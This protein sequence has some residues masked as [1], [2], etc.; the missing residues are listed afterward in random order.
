M[1]TAELKA[2]I[3][4]SLKIDPAKLEEAL[5]AEAETAVE[6][7]KDL[8]VLDEAGL[9]QLKNNEYASGKTKGVEMA[10]K[11]AKEKLGVETSSK[12]VDGLVNAATAKAL[13]DAKITPDAKVTELQKDLEKLRT[14]NATLTGT[15][16]E[17]EKIVTQA[18]TDRE[19]F[20]QI[21][22]LGENAP[23]VDMV[24]DI[25]RARGYDFQLQEGK[26]V[27][28]HG[29]EVVKDKVANV[30]PVKDII[31]GFAKESKLITEVIEPT[32]RGGAGG[33]HSV[34]FTKQS[35]V[36]ADFERQGKSINGTEYSD[37]VLAL[38]KANPE[39]KMEE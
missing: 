38:K 11:E 33:R 23:A 17:K 25:M 16:S 2:H 18:Q 35:E 5:K 31:S 7:A 14:E 10:V 12:T 4:T 22:S 19:L 20:K 6:Y 34:A 36:K 24:V 28:L 32:G 9:T 1:L 30:V 37:T 3:A 15:I 21:P 27:A 13:A 26:L 8:T 29:G 39:F